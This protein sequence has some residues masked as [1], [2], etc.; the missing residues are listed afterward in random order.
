MKKEKKK[1]RREEKKENPRCNS[2]SRGSQ[3]QQGNKYAEQLVVG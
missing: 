1:K 3:R 2:Q